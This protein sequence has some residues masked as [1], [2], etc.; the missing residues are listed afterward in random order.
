MLCRQYMKYINAKTVFQHFSFIHLLIIF[1]VISIARFFE[2]NKLVLI[3][4]LLNIIMFIE[5][6]SEEIVGV[7]HG[8]KTVIERY[9][10]I[11][12]IENKRTLFNNLFCL[13]RSCQHCGGIIIDSKNI[14]TAAHC[15]ADEFVVRVGSSQA[16]SGGAIVEVKKYLQ[17]EQYNFPR[18]DIGLIT[19]KEPLI[20]NST[21][22][23]INIAHQS[24][25]LHENR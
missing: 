1:D 22:K 5:G 17:H 14:V 21:V 2:M 16:D 23:R 7:R 9:P 11:A 3:F 15:L 8:A 20:F 13:F 4:L 25:T 18:H 10:W 12:L 6:Q 19:L 24:Y